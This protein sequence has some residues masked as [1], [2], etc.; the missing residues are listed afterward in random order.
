[1]PMLRNFPRILQGTIAPVSLFTWYQLPVDFM[2]N[3]FSNPLFYG[4]K[5]V[6]IF[7]KPLFFAGDNIVT[8]KRIKNVSENKGKPKA[9]LIFTEIFYHD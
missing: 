9:L 2:T 6:E 8:M 4:V 7:L 5:I 1:M 3:P